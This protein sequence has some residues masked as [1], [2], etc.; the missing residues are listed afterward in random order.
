LS[1]KESDVEHYA[2]EAASA[3]DVRQCVSEVASKK[4]KFTV[5]NLRSKILM[6]FSFF[7]ELLGIFRVVIVFVTACLFIDSSYAQQSEPLQFVSEFVREMDAMENIR[8]MIERELNEKVANPLVVGISSSTRVQLEL[9]TSIAMLGN[10]KLPG[11]F[12]DLPMNLADIYKQKDKTVFNATNLIFCSL[13]DMEPDRHGHA[14]HL[15]ITKA[16][17][18]QLIAR[19]NRQFGSKLTAKQSKST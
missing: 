2:E 8:S 5:T 7:R 13:I 14:S 4:R 6:K 10:F 16:E 11:Q 18:L 12:S 3:S 17:R 9:R 15:T 19:I 1:H